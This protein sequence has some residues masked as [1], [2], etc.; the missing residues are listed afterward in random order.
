MDLALLPSGTW[1][2]AAIF[3]ILTS[4]VCYFFIKFYKARMLF[5][6]RKRMGLVCFP[7]P[8][9]DPWIVEA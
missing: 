6:Q 2:S 7:Y 1:T 3:L 5:I 4:S 9:C 8:S